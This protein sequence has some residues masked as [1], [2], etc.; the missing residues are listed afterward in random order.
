MCIRDRHDAL[1]KRAVHQQA[2]QI[3]LGAARF[4][5]DDGL[6]RRADFL[7]LGK[8]DLQS[9]E[10]CLALGIV[11]YGGGQPGEAIEVGDFLFKRV[12]VGFGENFSRFVLGPFLGGFVQG[13]SLLHISEPTGPY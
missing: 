8:G 6:P 4:G 5:E 11:L 7:R 13:L 12:T 10:Q 2:Q 1:G 9:L 3:A